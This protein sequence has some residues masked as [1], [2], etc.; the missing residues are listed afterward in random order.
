[1]IFRHSLRSRII[2]AFC[3]FGGVLGSV[4]A[5][6]VYISLDYIDDS[7]INNS[8]KQEIDH[9]SRHYQ[10]DGEIAI[11]A[12][13][14]IKAYRGMASIP[15]PLREM[16][17]GFSE[18]LHEAYLEKEEYHV[19]VIS[20]PNFDNPLYL[21]FNVN[22]LEFTEKRKFRIAMVLVAGVIMVVSLGL[23]IGRL[24]SSR[25]IAPVIHLAQKVD[26]ADPGHLPTDLSKHFYQDEVGVLARTLEHSMQ[27]VE[28]FVDR[29]R[30]FT[31]NASHELRTPVAVIKGAV[32]L[33]QKNL[34]NQTAA[35][36]RPLNRLVRSVANMENI[37]EALLW[38]SREGVPINQQASFVV[39]P[40][41]RDTI[42]QNQKLIA[43]KPVDIN[44]VVSADPVLKMPQPMFQIALTNLIRN[45]VDHTA[46][47][48]ITVHVRDDRVVVSDTGEGIDQKDLSAVTQPHVSGSGSKG[49]GLGLTIVK[50]LCDR[51]NWQFHIQ[52]EI[53]VG[54]TA[55]LIFNSYEK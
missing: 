39:L 41:V 47:G 37:I 50:R 52:S 42:E 1:M 24:I 25:V 29:E 6:I 13:P 28:A 38:L 43:G 44:L 36:Q 32:E 31:R 51:L 18:G 34:D 53:D 33:L 54:T 55:E 16:V 20:L 9:I 27:R 5:F 12:S 14:H 48:T 11:P 22:A 30:R 46:S 4:F 23:W 7:L 19:A 40:V 21:F 8:L 35:V 3:L 10:Q 49:F 15:A 2:I 45:A 17:V 26:K